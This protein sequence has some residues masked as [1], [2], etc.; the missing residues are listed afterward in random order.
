MIREPARK[1]KH[2]EADN[3]QTRHDATE[4]SSERSLESV[5]INARV[6]LV[7]DLRVVDGLN[8][9]LAGVV[10]LLGGVDTS[11]SGG[12]GLLGLTLVKGVLVRGLAVDVALTSMLGSEFLE[13]KGRENSGLMHDGSLVDLLVNRNDGVNGLVGVGLL[14]D[15][16]LDVLV[17][18]VVNMLVDRG[19]KVSGGSLGLSDGLGVGVLLVLSGQLG[20]VLSGHLNPLLSG[21]LGDNVGLVLG[22]KGLGGGN[23]L[24]SVLVVVD[25]PLPVDSLG[26]LDVLVLGDVLLGDGGGSLGAD[27]G[28]SLLSRG[29]KEVLDLF[30][31]V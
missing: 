1:C 13:G 19:T 6:E 24:D 20:L 15:D 29:V 9:I 14:L 5:G 22:S 12:S 26:G 31:V 25:V 21:D 10:V 11:G 8:T 7:G 23:G 30:H 16:G 3:R 27:L 28:G 17:N 18:M 4:S 2:I